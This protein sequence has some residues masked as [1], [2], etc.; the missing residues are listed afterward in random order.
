MWRDTFVMN[1]DQS[2][3]GSTS[4]KRYPLD[5]I[6]VF[7]IGWFL[8]IIVSALLILVAILLVCVAILVIPGVPFGMAASAWC[9][10]ARAMFSGK[11]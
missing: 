6:F 11:D 3:P 8:G 1:N 2:I 5:T 7:I 4:D 10:G 9:K